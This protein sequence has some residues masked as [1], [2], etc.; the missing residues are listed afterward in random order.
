MNPYKQ[1]VEDFYLNM[2]LHTEMDLPSDRQSV[3]HFFERMSKKFPTMQNFYN[4]D[5][6]EYV[7]EEQKDGGSYRWTS[8]DPRRVHSGAVNP[9]TVDQAIEQHLFVL[10]EV[11]YALSISHLDCESLSLMYGFDFLYRGNHSQLLAEVLG[12]LPVFERMAGHTGS[13]LASYEPAIQFALD[14]SCRTQCRLSFEPRTSAASIR[15]GEYQEEQL[16]V[17]FTVRH[18]GS[19]MHEGAFAESLTELDKLSR[20]FVGDYLLEHVLVPLHQAIVI[21]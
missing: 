11:P 6:D 15:T 13:R 3:L 20:K 10:G 9:E 12:T 5:K 4:R 21:K 16:S 14:D 1:Y 7:L 18:F 17:Y 19:L 2:T 8:I